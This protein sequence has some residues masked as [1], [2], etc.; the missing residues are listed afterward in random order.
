MTPEH[1]FKLL[2]FS[3]LGWKDIHASNVEKADLNYSPQLNV[4]LSINY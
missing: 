2:A 3:G 4:N 1:F